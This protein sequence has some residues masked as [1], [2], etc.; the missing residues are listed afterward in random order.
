MRAGKTPEASFLHPSR[1]PLHR[2]FFIVAGIVVFLAAGYWSYAAYFSKRLPMRGSYA[3]T[4]ALTSDKISKSAAIYITLPDGADPEAAKQ[5]FVFYPKIKGEWLAN[6]DPRTIVF[7]PKKDLDVGKYYA[8][9]LPIGDTTLRHEFLVDE[10]PAIAAVFPKQDSE[11]FEESDI[12]II[13]NRPMVPLTTLAALEEKDVPVDIT[14]QTKGRFKWI[15][16]KNLQ[17]IPEDRLARSSKY[18]VAVKSGLVS[19]E[20]LAIQ[21]AA[22][23]FTTRRLR[24]EFISEGQ[25]IYNEPMR[26]QFNQPVD[27]KRTEGHIRVK[28]MTADHAADII[29][30]F[31]EKRVFDEKTKKY[32][33]EE[34]RNTL[35]VYQKK[36]AHGRPKLWDFTHHYALAIDT[37]YPEEGD[38]L[39]EEQRTA[40]IAVS[41]IV[42]GTSVTS[43]RSD[44]VFQDVFDPQGKFIISFFEEI[45]IKRSV[46][47]ADALSHIEYGE[48]CKEEIDS[49]EGYGPDP[50]TCEKAPDKKKLILS[51]EHEKIK[52]SEDIAVRLKKIVNTDGVAINPNEQA[53]TLKSFG[54]LAVYATLPLHDAKNASITQLTLC[55]PTPLAAPDKNAIDEFLKVSPEYQFERWGS[56]YRIERPVGPG[57]GSYEPGSGLETD[58]PCAVGQFATYISYGLM[59]NTAYSI[60]LQLEDDF[61]QRV[62]YPLS[63]HTGALP[64]HQLNFYH[65]Q[66]HYS[67]ASPGK[68]KLT[69]AAQ[70]MTFVNLHVCKLAPEQLLRHLQRKPNFTE[71]PEAISDCAEQQIHR[72][73]LP[74]RFWI[75]NFFTVNIAD[76]FSD[77][78][79]HYVLTF[80]HPDYV[81]GQAK[82]QPIFERTYLSVSNLSVVEKKI[83][84]DDA[85]EQE[86]SLTS[87]QKDQLKNLYW[88]TDITTL[89]SIRGAEVDL[90]ASEGSG[91]GQGEGFTRSYSAQT[92]SDGIAKTPAVNRLAGAVARNGADSALIVSVETTLSNNETASQARKL[93]MYSDRPI[94]RPGHEVFV[95]GMYRIGYDG[96][97]EIFR[98]KEVTLTLSDSKGEEVQSVELPVSDF[99][100]FDTKFLLSPDAPLGTYRVCAFEYECH[101]FSVEEYVPSAFRLNAK[102]EKPEYISGDLAA[103]DVEASYFFGVPLEEGEVEYT[104]A[105]QDYYFD[106]YQD[107]YFSFGASWYRC[108][109]ECEYGDAYLFRKK[110]PLRSDGKIRIAETMDLKK[111]FPK[112]EAPSSKIIIAYITVRNANGQ[113]VSTQ[114]SFIVHAGEFYA[115]VKTDPSFAG[116]GEQIAVKVKTVGIEG[117]PRRAKDLAVTVNKLRW[118]RYKRKEVDGSYYYRW[119]EE[120]TPVLTKTVDTNG[121][122]NASID[123]S[124]D[125]EGS[126]E[127]IV[128][129]EDAKGNIIQ[130]IDRLYVYGDA[131]ADV[132]PSNDTNLELTVKKSEVNVGDTAEFIVQS[133]FEKGKA[134]ITIERGKI[135]EYAI[136]DIAGNL[137]RHTF[138]VTE[139]H[140]PN[141]YASVTLLSSDPQVKFGKTQFSVG[142]KEKELNITITPDKKE[143]L[144]G[145]TVSL[146]VEARD[147]ANAP[148]ETELS[149]AVAD[150][151]VLAL[152]GN[153]KKNPVVF[154][155]DGFPLTVST[156]SNLKNIL[157]EVEIIPGKGG[158]G[159]EG[160]EKKKRG[161][162]K[163]TA[164][165]VAA[166]KTDASGIAAVSFALPDNLTTWQAETVGI[167]KDT[168]VGAAYSEFLARKHVMVVPIKPRFIIP[169]DTFSLGAQV[170]NETKEHQ[171]LAIQLESGS[172]A[173]PKDSERTLLIPSGTD[174]TVFFT[175]TAPAATEEG[176]HRFTL[177][178][179]NKA[180]DDT[181]EQSIAITRNLTYETTAAAGYTKDMVAK[182]Y[183]Y[184]PDNVIKNKG[185]LTVK[186]NATLA[187]FLS[188]A[189]KEMIQYPYGCSEQIASKLETIATVMWAKQ[190]KNIGEKIELAPIE[191]AGSVYQ[192]EELVRAGLS[193][194]YPKQNGDG[195]FT[196][197]QSESDVH[198]TL[199]IVNVL[200]NLKDA[201]FRVNQT[202]IDRAVDYVI[203]QINNPAPHASLGNDELIIAAY[204]IGRTQQ[205]SSP[206]PP[207]REKILKLIDNKQYLNEHISH[208]SL[209]HLA[210]VVSGGGYKE[211]VKDSVFKQLENRIQIDARGAFLGN[212][213][214]VLWRYYETPVKNTALLLKALV[215]DTRDNNILDKLLRWLL[216]SRAKDGAWG[217]T[218][219]TAAVVDAMTD[220]LI[221]KKEAES[222]F[223]LSVQL[224]G[225]EKGAHSFG[226][227]NILSEFQT[228]IPVSDIPANKN[229]TL[230][231]R[232]EAKNTRPNTLYYDLALR[233]FLPVEQLPPR[234][235][236]FTITRGLYR[237]ADAKGEE[238]VAEAAV[239]EVLRGHL[240]IHV[241]EGRNFVAVEDFIPAGFEI[242]NFSLATEDQSLQLSEYDQTLRDRR[243][244]SDFEE[245]H[246][247]RLFLFREFVDQGLY[248]FDYFIR[249]LVP[250]EFHHLPAVASEM[251]FPEHF[252][253]T[254]GGVVKVVGK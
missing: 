30:A 11:A 163:D 103:I 202:V 233:Y 21:E 67:V 206:L 213:N 221:W 194:L 223:D 56:S 1:Q 28:D 253:R 204:T 46:I 139:A 148:V 209:A 85:P 186:G 199:H 31:G 150:L 77:P 242:V 119:Q 174:K 81:T 116:K 149:V 57:L 76:Y 44:R 75:K 195:G 58:S 240:T 232:K 43:D 171:R 207:F 153:P 237:L 110:M 114:Q 188:D 146:R 39:L 68:T 41:D 61:G 66:K 141:I 210:M 166:V 48:K 37:A 245:S 62:S 158:G 49:E 14:P 157:Q 183:V 176:S 47:D 40:A 26:I 124:P 132:E 91:E 12:T 72:L 182:E 111:L 64:P 144:P 190:L 214:T 134:L 123:F 251:Y 17:F 172:L 156:G 249:A 52:N 142:R 239:G 128:K 217:S 84:R 184:L 201:G 83:K 203:Q 33:K 29:V 175:V 143:Y 170:F 208:T 10:N 60:S 198:L 220:Y 247:D 131:H 6:S 121:D 231:F 193:E 189:L 105:A 120:R 19:M 197:Y 125:E 104:L 99:G 90:Y 70:N 254:N 246:D 107:E 79:G 180:Y 122:G 215:A 238:T 34:D 115:G 173:L 74:K 69:Y 27:I 38:I 7:Q 162:F 92:N 133:P 224:N 135:F 178:A 2:R 230:I 88:I 192:P 241:P 234:D 244:Y 136:V 18:S 243:W 226:G 23:G 98:D 96:S 45:D 102:T 78:L 117:E 3:E 167:T 24:Y 181:V 95:K 20:G 73:D 63:F 151:S 165:W 212:G 22:F 177:S 108:A 71:G 5:N 80:S 16:T 228:M 159:G 179:K 155:Y 126:Y 54:D 130:G 218:N 140:I 59:P 235:E 8:L 250:G 205:F 161:L 127:I 106:R 53:F 227:E 219:N 187:V 154:F 113:S 15:S 118:A 211:S 97:Y 65:Y 222:S 109:W 225:E 168:R 138:R 112:E 185:G 152:K 236:G 160:I 94:Y 137:Y 164:Y 51:F 25:I 216:A 55:T 89:E 42:V 32:A 87:S 100:T 35:L 145:E 129:G 252:G 191:H 147:H 93:Y 169:G 229:N 200:E 82:S 101:S 13:F 9:E 4:Y 248:E 86:L 50:D 196:Y 36:D